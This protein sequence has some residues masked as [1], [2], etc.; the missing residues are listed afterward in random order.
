M[1]LMKRAGMV[2][3]DGIS[4]EVKIKRDAKLAGKLNPRANRM[5]VSNDNPAD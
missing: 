3:H 5:G 4:M 2:V 1:L